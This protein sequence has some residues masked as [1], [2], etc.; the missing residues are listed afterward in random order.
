VTRTC[1]T[2]GSA[3]TALRDGDAVE[4]WST[5]DG[6][7]RKTRGYFKMNCGWQN[8]NFDRIGVGVSVRKYIA[9]FGRKNIRT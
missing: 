9:I 2:S 3:Q 7:V 5:S 4:G 8:Y 1:T 6:H